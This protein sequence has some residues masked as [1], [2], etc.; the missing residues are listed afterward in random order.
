MGAVKSRTIMIIYPCIFR[1]I[2]KSGEHQGGSSTPGGN[3]GNYV[4]VRIQK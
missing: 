4:E 3:K 1:E 2:D